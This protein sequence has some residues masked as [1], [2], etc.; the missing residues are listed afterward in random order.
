MRKFLK[1]IEDNRPGEDKYTVELKDVTGKVVRRFAISGVG[2]PFENFLAFETSVGGVEVPVAVE[3]QEVKS[4]GP[5]VYDVDSE[6]SKLA[7]KAESG[8][9]GLAGKMEGTGTQQDKKAVKKREKVAKD[10]VKIY[11]KD[12]ESLKQAIQQK[13]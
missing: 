11:K 9:L 3:D 2:S 7:S 10:A 5:G 8:A 13:I 4:G 12:T 1:L 6:V